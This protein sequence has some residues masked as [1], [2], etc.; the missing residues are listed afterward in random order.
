MHVIYI[1]IAQMPY[2]APCGTF[3]T[4]TTEK[5]VKDDTLYT[6]Q[7]QAQPTST[8]LQMNLKTCKH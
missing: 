5:W 3:E 7:T 6:Q 8:Q 1:T 4:L 2:N